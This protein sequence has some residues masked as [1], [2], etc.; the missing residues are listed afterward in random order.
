MQQQ[1][2]S[3]SGREPPQSSS[4]D[5]PIKQE[6]LTEEIRLPMKKEIS[7]LTVP[8]DIRRLRDEDV[9]KDDNWR[10]WKIRILHLLSINDLDKYPLSLVKKPSRRDEYNTWR[11][12]DEAAADIII[13]N[14]SS[15]QFGLVP[16][17]FCMTEQ[18]R[19]T[20]AQIWEGLCQQH[21]PPV[22]LYTSAIEL[23]RLYTARADERS[24]IAK[25]LLDMQTLRFRLLTA[26]HHLRD[27]EF[28][29]NLLITS[30]P[31]SWHSYAMSVFGIPGTP[32][33]EQNPATT[34][35]LISTLLSEDRRRTASEK[36]RW[37]QLYRAKAGLP[38]KRKR[39]EEPCAICSKANHTTDC[40][41]WKQRGGYCTRCQHGGHW[42]RNCPG[43][44]KG[45]QRANNSGTMFH[46]V[47]APMDV[48]TSGSSS[49]QCAQSNYISCRWAAATATSHI[50][51]DRR[52][53]ITYTEDITKLQTLGQVVT[54]VGRGTVILASKVGDNTY[55]MKLHDTLHVPT[56][57]ENVF[58]L[59]RF[60]EGGGQFAVKDGVASFYAKGN[61]LIAVG[62]PGGKHNL[63]CLDVQAKADPALVTEGRESGEVASEVD[64]MS[65]N[66]D[67]DFQELCLSVSSLTR[68]RT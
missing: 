4:I 12:L 51:N 37:D 65:S 23:R 13:D 24:D 30:L 41:H 56:A 60:A 61:A 20:S 54:A 22:S 16:G 2:D 59:G 31:E 35:Q 63:F 58:S 53:F 32:R 29:N 42:T 7:P 48:G 3:N 15:S 10:T 44:D 8:V 49:K 57:S 26:D 18:K 64:G 39:D 28:F 62:R 1:N 25:Y 66:D 5:H 52:M 67:E 43:K 68:T 21:E 45:K 11:M 36:E 19:P 34:V 33:W 46:A 27:D 40:C 17:L 38:N 47:D 14:I 50:A 9:L 6:P 55:K